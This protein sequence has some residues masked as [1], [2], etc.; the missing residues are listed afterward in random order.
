[1]APSLVLNGFKTT[2][3]CNRI[4]ILEPQT[5]I[6]FFNFWADEFEALKFKSY[7]RFQLFWS[8]L[9]PEKGAIDIFIKIYQI[10]ASGSKKNWV[11]KGNF[12]KFW[13]F[14]EI[15]LQGKIVRLRSKSVSILL[16]ILNGLV[17]ML[18]KTP[19]KVG[20][21]EQKISDIDIK[22]VE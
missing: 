13:F 6:R 18:I 5:Y 2:E 9:V 10:M 4:W 3:I 15:Q 20:W 1:M 8:F 11:Y 22:K 14:T 21:M 12:D 19:S 7:Y 17:K 16:K